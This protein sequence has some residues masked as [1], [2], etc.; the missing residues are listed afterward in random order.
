MIT[1][2]LTRQHIAFLVALAFVSL[3]L[4]VT[5]AA[6]TLHIDITHLASSGIIPDFLYRNP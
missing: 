3:L 6:F 5:V 4:L 1:R 2:G